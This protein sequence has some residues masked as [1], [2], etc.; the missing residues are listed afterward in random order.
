MKKTLPG[1]FANPIDHQLN[2][3]QGSFHSDR[4]SIVEVYRE[5]IK[6]KI[7][8]I[9]MDKDFVYKKDVEITTDEGKIIK[10]IIGRTGSSLLTINN[11]IIN[12]SKIKDINKI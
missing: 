12:F 6:K 2:N 5:D 11:E 8:R 10:T 9:F 4:G 3:T 7:N 1:I